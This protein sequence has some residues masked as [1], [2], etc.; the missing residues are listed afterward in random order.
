VY[1]KHSLWYLE[2]I[3]QTRVYVTKLKILIYINIRI[4]LMVLQVI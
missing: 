3:L 2:F 1:E 4:N